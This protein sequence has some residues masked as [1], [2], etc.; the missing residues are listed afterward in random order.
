MFKFGTVKELKEVSKYVA[1]EPKVYD[2]CFRMVTMLDECYG[3]NRDV[4]KDYGGVVVLLVS[5]DD[6]E[7][8]CSDTFDMFDEIEEVVEMF[9]N[10]F[11]VI[12][13]VGNDY[14]INVIVKESNTP[15]KLKNKWKEVL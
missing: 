10:Y 14:G 4:I 9:D 2:E 11:N 12:Y 1:L 5:V 3:A 7:K 13:V 15:L 6:V 8:F